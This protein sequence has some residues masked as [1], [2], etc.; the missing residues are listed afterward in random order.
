MKLLKK[1]LSTFIVMLVVMTSINVVEA[2]ALNEGVYIVPVSVDYKNPETGL[3]EDG[4]SLENYELG[5]SMCK[6][7]VGSQSLIEIENGKKYVTL[8]FS[9]MSNISNISIGVQSS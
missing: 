2:K 6:S 1:L 5:L 7:I 4:G 8:R 9:L 3:I